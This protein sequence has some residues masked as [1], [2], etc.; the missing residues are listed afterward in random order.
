MS[1]IHVQNIIPVVF[2]FVGNCQLGKAY[3]GDCSDASSQEEGEKKCI[4]LVMFFSDK[5]NPLWRVEVSGREQQRGAQKKHKSM[6]NE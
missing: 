3:Q 5:C 6:S 1:L 2:F 4:Y